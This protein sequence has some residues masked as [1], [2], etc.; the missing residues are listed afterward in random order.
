MEAVE[1]PDEFEIAHIM[2]EHTQVT[3]EER[4]GAGQFA[5]GLKTLAEWYCTTNTWRVP[6]FLRQKMQAYVGGEVPEQAMAGFLWD[7]IRQIP[8]VQERGLA[9]WRE[10]CDS[11]VDPGTGQPYETVEPCTTT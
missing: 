2:Y 10:R 6:V 8:Q 5:P 3:E 11:G 1:V 9:L 7:L 4:E